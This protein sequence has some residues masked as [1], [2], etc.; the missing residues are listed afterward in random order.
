[1]LPHIGTFEYWRA[2][3]REIGSKTRKEEAEPRHLPACVIDTTRNARGIVVQCMKSIPL[4]SE[5]LVRRAAAAGTG[6]C[7][8][9]GYKRSNY[10]C[11][12]RLRLF[13]IQIQ[14]Y[15][16]LYAGSSRT[17]R[18]AALRSKNPT[19]DSRGRRERS[20]DCKTIK[21]SVNQRNWKYLSFSLSP[22]QWYIIEYI[23]G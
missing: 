5:A 20:Q 3:Y 16:Y 23:L 14:I 4:D 10:G 2:K 7:V 9:T 22:L 12:L 21:A 18:F 1:M 13:M 6:C 15:L 11:P 19:P 8:M 17:P